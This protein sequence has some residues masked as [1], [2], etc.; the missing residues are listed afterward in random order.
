MHAYEINSN[1][2]SINLLLS[3]RFR[4]KSC[5]QNYKSSKTS[6][7]SNM[8]IHSYIVYGDLKGLSC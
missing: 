2:S 8:I 5:M 7:S 1:G 4:P 3:S 6:H